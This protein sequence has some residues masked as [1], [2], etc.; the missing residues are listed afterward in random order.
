M[1]KK[2][3]WNSGNSTTGGNIAELKKPHVRMFPGPVKR[4]VKVR[5]FTYAGS[6]FGAVHWWADI[7]EEGNPIW[8]GNCWRT[9]WDDK[10]AEGRTV[11]GHLNTRDEALLWAEATCIEMFS[12]D[13]H[14]FLV[15]RGGDRIF[16]PV[17]FDAKKKI[18][19]P[20]Q[21]P[22]VVNGK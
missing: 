10:A 13:T 7:A 21:Q 14:Q 4:R 8:D 11:Q 17:N 2:P 9:F 22:Y 1:R 20:K 5:V 3:D 18:K 16:F 15:D 19:K 12:A 6:C